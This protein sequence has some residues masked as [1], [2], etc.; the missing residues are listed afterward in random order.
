[1]I[2]DPDEEG[3]FDEVLENVNLTNQ[4]AS[5]TLFDVNDNDGIDDGINL[6]I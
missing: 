4:M 1:M 5:F 3:Y 6:N 2:D